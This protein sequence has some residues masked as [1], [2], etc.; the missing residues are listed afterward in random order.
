MRKIMMFAI[1]CAGLITTGCVTMPATIEPTLLSEMTDDQKNQI[2]QLNQDIVKKRDESVVAQKAYAGSD[3]VVDVS[4]Q[5][6]KS[7]EQNG[8]LLDSQMGM[9]N[10][11]GN[12]DKVE[13]I[14]K[15]IDQ[16][17]KRI[18]Q[19]KANLEYQTTKRDQL[20]IE[21][22]ISELELSSLLAKVNLIKAKAA[23]DYQTKRQEKEPTKVEDY[24]KYSDDLDKKIVSKQE[25]HKKAVEKTARAKEALDKTGYGAKE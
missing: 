25:D 8:K 17:N 9:Y 3:E 13:E 23:F 12:K 5:Q 4:K 14:A 18:V 6:I 7:Y 11:Q 1:L 22:E 21:K 15:L 19:E 20:K 10:E 16:N 2:Q 24:Q